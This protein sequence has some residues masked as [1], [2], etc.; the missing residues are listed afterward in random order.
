MAVRN[1]LNVTCVFLGHIYQGSCKG[2]A[3][4]FFGP[5][6][7]S[8]VPMSLLSISNSIKR[9]IGEDGKLTQARGVPNT[10]QSWICRKSQ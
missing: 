1:L 8:T 4:S 3:R 9:Q 10:G 2:V 6:V 5:I 7:C